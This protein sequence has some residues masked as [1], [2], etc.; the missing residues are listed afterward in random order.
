M[1][2]SSGPWDSEFKLGFGGCVCR[3][4]FCGVS[5]AAFT[6]LWVFSRS[7]MEPLTLG[8]RCY[9]C[10]SLQKRLQELPCQ[11]YFRATTMMN[12]HGPPAQC[13][14]CPGPDKI[15]QQGCKR[16]GELCALHGA[17]VSP[18]HSF[19]GACPCC[20]HPHPLPGGGGRHSRVSRRAQGCISDTEM[21]LDDLLIDVFVYLVTSVVCF[22]PWLFLP[23]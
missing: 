7:G 1:S 16:S 3:C 2:T 4:V 22:Y 20:Q 5:L 14:T 19:P 11:L 8:S 12:R 15:S 17:G 9:L 6:N 21:G 23:C 18:T 10:S 13:S